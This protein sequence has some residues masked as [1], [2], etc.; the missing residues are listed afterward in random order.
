MGAGSRCTPF[1]WPHRMLRGQCHNPR[2]KEDAAVRPRVGWLSG[3]G[4]FA[5][6]KCL[7]SLQ[8]YGLSRRVS[9]GS[10]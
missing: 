10:F 7:I 5:A 6:S 2:R 9:Q 8:Y 3:A 1:V 4:P